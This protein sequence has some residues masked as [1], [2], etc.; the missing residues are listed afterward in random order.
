[1]PTESD[2]ADELID[3][4]NQAI[5]ELEGGG[6]TCPKCGGGLGSTTTT[7]TDGRRYPERARGENKISP[8][9]MP[10]RLVE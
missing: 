9:R 8:A 6:S 10:L 2:D 5:L 1:M 7:N 4:Y 3:A